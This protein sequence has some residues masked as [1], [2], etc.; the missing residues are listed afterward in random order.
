MNIIICISRIRIYNVN[1]VETVPFWMRVIFNLFRFWMTTN[2]SSKEQ[3]FSPI[4]SE[5]ELW[6]QIELISLS[7]CTLFTNITFKWLFYFFFLMLDLRLDWNICAY[8]RTEMFFSSPF[9]IIL[10]SSRLF[11]SLTLSLSLAFS[12]FMPQKIK[13]ISNINF[14]EYRF[15]FLCSAIK[16]S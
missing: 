6:F 14:M 7:V 8:I 16:D 12:L 11:S 15:D 1:R 9:L 3:T 5:K 2:T 13:E 10:K 4:I